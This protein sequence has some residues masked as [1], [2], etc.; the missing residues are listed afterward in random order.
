MARLPQL[1]GGVSASLAS[2]QLWRRSR[3]FTIFVE[4]SPHYAPRVHGTPSFI[5]PDGCA[6]IAALSAE[7]PG[8]GLVSDMDFLNIIY[9]TLIARHM[10][11]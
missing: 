2:R 6:M 4:F 3:S 9:A 1:S 11:G 5:P 10:K 8:R 7:D